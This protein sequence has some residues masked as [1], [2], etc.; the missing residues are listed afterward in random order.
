MYVYR[1]AVKFTVSCSFVSQTLTLSPLFR[2][3]LASETIIYVPLILWT[4]LLGQEEAH[5]YA[6]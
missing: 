6:S 5:L 3:G 1:D 2:G 4:Y